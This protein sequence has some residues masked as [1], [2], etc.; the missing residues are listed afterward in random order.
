MNKT[1]PSLNW[2]ESP[3][4]G[5][6]RYFRARTPLGTYSIFVSEDRGITLDLGEQTIGRYEDVDTAK[7]K[8]FQHMAKTV[9][10]CLPFFTSIVKANSLKA[11]FDGIEVSRAD[12]M[13]DFDWFTEGVSV[14]EK[15]AGVFLEVMRSEVDKLIEGK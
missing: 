15:M 6:G 5:G 3:S 10:G 13:T 12:G 14:G 9:G 2:E 11:L 8:A 7:V 4:F 1:L